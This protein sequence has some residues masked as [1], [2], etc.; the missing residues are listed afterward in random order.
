MANGKEADTQMDCN[1]R[2]ERLVRIVIGREE[3]RQ[4]PWIRSELRETFRG[5]YHE[6]RSTGHAPPSQRYD[7]AHQIERPRTEPG[8]TT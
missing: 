3:I 6:V 4:S 1:G 2:H 5:E 8:V 7:G